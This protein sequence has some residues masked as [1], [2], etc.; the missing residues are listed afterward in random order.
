MPDGGYV[1]QPGDLLVAVP[2]ALV[3]VFTA[4]DKKFRGARGGRGSGK[5]RTFAKMAAI[6]GLEFASAGKRGIIVCGRELM[7]SL[8]DS[9]F[10]EVKAAILSDPWLA[11]NYDIGEKYIRTK[12]GRIDFVFVGLRHN[13]D[14]IKSKALILLVWIDEAERVSEAAWVKLIPTV[15]DDEAEIWITYNRERE[16]SAT[17]QRFG[18]AQLDDDMIFVDLNYDGNPWFPKTLEAERLR[19]LRDRPEEYPHIWLGEYATAHK[20]AYFAKFLAAAKEEGRICKLA[21]EPGQAIRTYHDLAGSSDKADAYAMWVVQF[22]GREIRVLDHYETIGQPPS[23]HTDWLKEWCIRRKIRRAHVYLPHDGAHVLIDDSWKKIWEAASSIEMDEVAYSVT[24]INN[25]GKGA[26]NRRIAAAKQQFSKI[27]FNEVPTKPGRD[28]LGFYH[29]RWD[30]ERN[31]GLGADHDW[32]SHSA[33]AFGMMC[34]AYKPPGG[35]EE[36]A[37][38]LFPKYGT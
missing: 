31:I 25:Q 12:C 19:D 11:A 26:A 4:P 37:G 5:T 17:N 34:E 2:P 15:R 29:E 38:P 18:K 6:K 35:E 1:A 32:S 23:H 10:A 13:L 16:N 9:S 21:L 3:P 33:D 20:G 24:V 28:A 8:D 14:S 7:N 30:T 22:V 36:Y 27:H